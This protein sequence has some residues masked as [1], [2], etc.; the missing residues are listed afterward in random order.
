[1]SGVD[2]LLAQ[3][4]AVYR[5]RGADFH[6]LAL[7]RMGSSEQA[8]DAVQEGFAHAIGA[9][10]AYRGGGSLEAWIARCVINAARDAQRRRTRRPETL[11]GV[12]GEGAAR[13]R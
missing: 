7:A 9:R 5:A 4:E 3:I 10:A 1:M 11:A 6:R 13:R 8:W 2:C 12:D